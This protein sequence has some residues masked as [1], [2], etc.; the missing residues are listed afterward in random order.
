VAARSTNFDFAAYVSALE[1]KDVPAW[2]RFFA[3]DAEWL[4]YR[5][6]NPPRAPN[7]MRGAGEIRAFLEGVAASPVE[8]QVSHE[9]VGPARAAY[10][11]TVRFGDGRRIIE[12]VILELADGKIASEI[13]V[14]AWD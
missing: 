11:L 3:D 10:R 8:L 6:R 13:D 7:V 1:Q 12:H 9:L 4:E 5:E 14:E 2:I